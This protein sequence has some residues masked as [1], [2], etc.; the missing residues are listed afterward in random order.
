[1]K[2]IEKIEKIKGIWFIIFIS[3]FFFL[4]RLPSLIEPYWYGDEGIYE[5]IGLALN[6]GRMLYSQ[7]WDNKPPLLYFIYAIAHADQFTVR[8]LSILAGVS[9]TIFFYYLSK[10][11]F[12]PH[13]ISAICTVFY[14]LLFAT[15][16]IEGNIANAENF[17]LLPI[18]AAALFIYKSSEA[19]RKIHLHFGKY[20]IFNTNYLILLSAG[21]LLG[22]AFLLKIVALFDFSAFFVFLA[23]E[24]KRL[25][26]ELAKKLAIYTFGFLAPIT[27][28][29]IYFLIQGSVVDFLQATFFSNIGYVDYKNKFIISQ[30]FL[31]L[32][33]L[34]LFASVALVF[35]KGR[36]IP[37][38]A[39]FVLLWL[40]FSTFNVFF[41]GRNWN[42]YLLVL[43]P[44]T[45][46]LLGLLFDRIAQKIRTVILILL[47][48][49]IYCVNAYF[50]V[51]IGTIGKAIQYY[52]NFALF[53]ADKKSPIEYQKY[54]DGRVPGDYE[55]ARFI[56]NNIKPGEYVFIWGNNPQIYAL[57][58]TLPPGKYIV[59]YHISQG[60]K[61]MEETVEDLKRTKPKYLIILS[62]MTGF[63][64]SLGE[65]INKYNFAGA[66]IYER[67][68]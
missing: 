15:P 65:Y 20:L 28:A 7:I 63:P 53:I 48:A 5:V 11:L 68:F 52:Q 60:S 50:K 8:L 26:K 2:F 36:N 58:N 39:M 44:S 40:F 18:I 14:V 57:S 41:S 29:T 23:W 62:D 25:Y 42:H 6:N 45:I 16:V 32:K 54:F 49:I 38:S 59:E 30:G 17:M 55:I 22:V 21:L 47:L 13:R 12:R 51:G 33:L 31:L 3:F 1:M 24:H 10:N 27:L 67:T 64:F 4:L 66:N 35:W 37:K 34:A 19:Q 61:A 9:S 46:L 56:K 43:L